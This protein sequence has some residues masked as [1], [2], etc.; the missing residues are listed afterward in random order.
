MAI[1]ETG[2]YWDG[3]DVSGLDMAFFQG[4]AYVYPIIPPSVEDVDPI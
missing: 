3:T 1:D 2:V 4:I